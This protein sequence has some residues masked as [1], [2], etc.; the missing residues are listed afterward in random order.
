MRTF[1]Q[2]FVTSFGDGSLEQLHSRRLRYLLHAKSH[3]LEIRVV[4][5]NQEMAS[6]VLQ[7]D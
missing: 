4:D 5:V 1:L 7:A 6:A 2:V 3:L